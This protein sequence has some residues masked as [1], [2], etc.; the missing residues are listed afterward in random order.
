MLT[1]AN[2]EI[3]AIIDSLVVIKDPTRDAVGAALKIRLEDAKDTTASYEYYEGRLPNGPLDRIEAGHRPTTTYGN[4]FLFVRDGVVIHEKDLDLNRFGPVMPPQHN[5]NDGP[6]GTTSYRYQWDNGAFMVSFV[7][8]SM[9]SRLT[10][11]YLI[12]SKPK[13]K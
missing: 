6:E 11:I 13:L 8:T 4:V 9:S 5:P 10:G 12:W 3:M 2:H 1:A 7:F